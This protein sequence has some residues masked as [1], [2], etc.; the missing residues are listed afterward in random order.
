MSLLPEFGKTMPSNA[1]ISNKYL[2]K[3]MK[4]G[5]GGLRPPCDP[6]AKNYNGEGADLDLHFW[7]ANPPPL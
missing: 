5:E 4:I 6:P 2:A 1:F 7:L 3:T